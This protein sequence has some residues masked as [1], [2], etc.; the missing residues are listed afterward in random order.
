MPSL[1][2]SHL[3]SLNTLASSSSLHTSWADTVLTSLTGL[4]KPLGLP[5]HTPPPCKPPFPSPSL[6]R[7]L[8]T[9]SLPPLPST[10]TP[11]STFPVTFVRWPSL[12]LPPLPA[13]HT[14]PR[15]GHPLLPL[16]PRVPNFL[17]PFPSRSPLPSPKPPS[18][19]P[20]PPRTAPHPPE[21]SPSLSHSP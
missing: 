12:N 21:C 10:C 7:P 14:Q 1:G 2:M 5:S 20:E 6:Q 11:S 17:L 15:P 4:P 8:D 16:L 18:H 9:P 13:P 3:S 19:P